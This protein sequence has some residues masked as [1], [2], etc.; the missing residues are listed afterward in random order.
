MTIVIPDWV[1]LWAFVVLQL[2]NVAVN[3]R[4]L[5]WKKR[6][7]EAQH[8]LE[9]ARTNLAEVRRARARNWPTS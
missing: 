7:V 2:A 5:Y 3:F 9:E 6:L 8:D 4:L 1:V